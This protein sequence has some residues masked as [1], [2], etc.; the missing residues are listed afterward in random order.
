MWIRKKT[1]INLIKE[2]YEQGLRVGVSIKQGGIYEGEPRIL[3]EAERILKE[4]R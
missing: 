1:F 4:R 2:A 3:R